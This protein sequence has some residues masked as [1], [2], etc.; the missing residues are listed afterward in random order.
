MTNALKFHRSG[1][2]PEI[3][4]APYRAVE[5]DENRAGVVVRDRGIGVEPAHAHRIFQLF[6]RA[7]GREVRGTGAG[8][9]IVQQVA[10]R[11]GGQA[12]AQPREGGGS[13]FILLFGS[14]SIVNGSGSH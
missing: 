4:I 11:H 2:A 6:Q 1:Q 10:Q 13:E 9:A 14:N 3:D 8:L 7:V 12:W 5:E